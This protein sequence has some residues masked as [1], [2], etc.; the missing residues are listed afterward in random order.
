MA[1][2]PNESGLGRFFH[3]HLKDFMRPFLLQQIQNSNGGHVFFIVRPS[4]FPY[5]EPEHL[6]LERI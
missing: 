2:H 3:F 5:N 4:P 1:Q 6:F